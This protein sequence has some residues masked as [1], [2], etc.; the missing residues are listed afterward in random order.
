MSIN[1]TIKVGDAV[2]IETV[3]D[4][5]VTSTT[6]VNGQ[7]VANNPINIWNQRP[8]LIKLVND[9]PKMQ[10]DAFGNIKFD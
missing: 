1:K 4:S 5:K 10:I 9:N 2:Y 3:T 6:T 7:V 8:S